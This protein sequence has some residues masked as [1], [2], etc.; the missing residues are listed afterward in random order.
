MPIRRGFSLSEIIIAI[1]L[2]AI[3]VVG[4]ASLTVAVWKATKFAKYTA[5]AS[6]LARQPLER[7]RGDSAFFNVTLRGPA[8]ERRFREEFEVDQ[9]RTVPFE[10][11][12]TFTPLAAPQDRYVRV[13]S[14]VFWVQQRVR[15]EVVLETIL[16]QPPQY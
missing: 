13:T 9:G 8:S 11:E 15:R 10:G 2:A 1:A 5:F 6:N 4:L 16:P 12:L 14:R 7:M 3:A